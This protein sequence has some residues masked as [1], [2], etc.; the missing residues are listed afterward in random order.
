MNICGYITWLNYLALYC[1]FFSISAERR[2]G[3]SFSWLDVCWGILFVCCSGAERFLKVGNARFFL[4]LNEAVPAACN[5]VLTCS[6]AGAWHEKR[7]G[8]S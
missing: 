1:V 2:E 8:M 7:N 5:F 6:R 3:L 4:C